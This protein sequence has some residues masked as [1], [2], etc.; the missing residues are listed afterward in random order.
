MVVLLVI[1]VV[2]TGE[3]VGLYMVSNAEFAGPSHLMVI[4]SVAGLGNAEDCRVRIFLAFS[5][6]TGV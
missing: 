3:P 5:T 2:G 1:S 6:V 4:L